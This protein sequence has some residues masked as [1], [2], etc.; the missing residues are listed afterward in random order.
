MTNQPEGPWCAIAAW[1]FLIVIGILVY[2]SV[3]EDG[4]LREK[5]PPPK[6]IVT[7]IFQIIK[8]GDRY[9]LMTVD[10][11]TKIV[12]IRERWFEKI[13]ADV[14]EG[15]LPWAEIKIRGR[16]GAKG[17]LGEG[18]ILHIRTP[19]DIKPGRIEGKYP[20]QMQEVINAER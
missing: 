13:I 1:A 2:G 19:K 20:V 17:R 11:D 5:Q 15:K 16:F 6:P 9:E 8:G 18:N 14:P 7:D 4:F 10:A 3:A 12:V